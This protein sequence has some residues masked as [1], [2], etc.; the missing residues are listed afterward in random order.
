HWICK[1]PHQNRSTRRTDP[2]PGRL[3]PSARW[4]AHRPAGDR[5]L[6]G[7]ALGFPDREILRLVSY[8]L[9]AF[10]QCF[11]LG[12]CSPDAAPPGGPLPPA[13]RKPPRPSNP[14]V[15]PRPQARPGPPTLAPA[16]HFRKG[17]F[18]LAL[19]VRLNA[20]RPLFAPLDAPPP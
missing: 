9:L 2:T 6:C 18:F 5:K 14:P 7:H 20:D 3:T 13:W 19:P 4:K 10:R 11:A 16:L 12:R 1:N 17:P 15:P 8:A